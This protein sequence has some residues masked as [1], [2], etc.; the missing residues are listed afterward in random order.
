M[1][2]YV[3]IIGL[4]LPALSWLQCQLPLNALTEQKMPFIR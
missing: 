2:Q 1:F 4:A 3:Y